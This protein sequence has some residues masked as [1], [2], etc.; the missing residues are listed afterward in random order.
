M[1]VIVDDTSI[2]VDG[3]IVETV[4][5]SGGYVDPLI[6]SEPTT[7]NS[8]ITSYLHDGSTNTQTTHTIILD[9]DTDCEILAVAGGG[10]GGGGIGGG[11]GAGAVVHIPSAKL[12]AGIYTIQVGNGGAGS[13]RTVQSGNGTQSFITGTGVNIIA[14][15]GGGVTGGH[16]FGDGLVGGSGGGAAGPYAALNTG[17]A[18]GTSSS[19]GGF[20]GF[21]YGNK[22]GSNT[23][24][25]NGGET[26]ATGGGG[27]GGAA[28]DTNPSAGAAGHGGVGKEINITGTNVFYGG[29]GGGAGHTTYA[30]LGGTG[31]GGNGS[32]NGTGAPGHANTGGGG[33]GGAWSE[34]YGGNGGSGIVIIRYKII[35]ITI[36]NDYK[37]FAFYFNRTNQAA[38]TIN[39][40]AYTNCDVLVVGGGGGAAGGGGGAGGYVYNTG[41]VLYGTYNILVGNGGA[42]VGTGTGGGNQGFASSFIGGTI[43]SIN[44]TA[45]GGGGGGGNGSAAPAHTVG[46]VGS[47]GGGGMDF[48]TVQTYTSTQGNRGGTTTYGGYGS[49]GGGGGAGA[50][51]GNPTSLTTS[52]TESY[53]ELGGYG[54]NGL[55][56]SIT[57]SILYY[58]GGGAGGTNTNVT[59]TPTTR[60][61]PQGGIGGGGN[62]NL[63]HIQTGFSG[64][65]GTGGGGGGGDWERTVPAGNGGS[66]IVIIRYQYTRTN[67]DAQWTYNTSNANVYHLGNVGIGT[68]NPIYSLHVN[69]N[70]QST[71][72]SASSKTF[73]IEHPLK[74]NKW[75]YHGCLEAPRFDNIYRGKKLLT[76]GKAEVDIDTECNTTG[77]MTPGTF[78]ILNTNAQLF[79]R[80]NQTYDRVKGKINGSTINIQCENT[81]DDIEIDWMVVGERHDEH[82]INTPLT[83]SYGNLICESDI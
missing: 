74:L 10:G 13:H 55:S 58:A 75:L 3:R 5:F 17:G 60:G 23:A 24:A 69:G 52:T 6:A 82:V 59:T 8:N 62:G 66:G 4:K 76:N 71:T 11:G 33:G 38:Y 34:F 56:N 43:N 28:I 9:R 46:Q 80:N 73:K 25:R 78:P 41:V 45:Y 79:L 21:I 81:T 35:A 63:Q 1:P 65:H 22:G 54:G 12:P 7:P 61:L 18:A 42:G 36:D 48:T 16:D 40:P 37:Y 30:G 31:G 29:G 72:Y 57:G 14:E 26:N 50:V 47:Y 20:T 51:G 77:G 39:F 49:G 15:G 83:D 53:R 44:Y 67:F 19:L 70:T 68:T 27:A 2:S 32:P 64:I